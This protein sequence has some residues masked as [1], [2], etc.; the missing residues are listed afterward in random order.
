MRTVIIETDDEGL[1]PEENFAALSSKS[2]NKPDE[3]ESLQT[4]EAQTFE[5]LK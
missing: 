2:K 4:S 3:E 1:F 5:A